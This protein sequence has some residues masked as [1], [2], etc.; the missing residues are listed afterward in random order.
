MNQ[1]F[2][3]LLLP[4][5]YQYFFKKILSPAIEIRGIRMKFEN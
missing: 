3:I 1:G 2:V 5:K 4:W